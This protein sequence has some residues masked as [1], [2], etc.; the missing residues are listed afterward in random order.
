MAVSLSAIA[1]AYGASDSARGILATSDGKNAPIPA[2]VIRAVS[3]GGDAAREA[4]HLDGIDLVTGE[5]ADT[6]QNRARANAS[7]FGPPVRYAVLKTDNPPYADRTLTQRD[8]WDDGVIYTSVHYVSGKPVGVLEVTQD[9]SF[10]GFGGDPADAALIAK[11][12]PSELIIQAGLERELYV[13]TNDLKQVR[14]L[15]QNAVTVIGPKAIGAATFRSVH[16]EFE[17]QAAQAYQDYLARTYPDGAPEGLLGGPGFVV[18]RVNDP[19]YRTPG[20]HGV[21]IACV[22]LCIAGAA[23]SALTVQRRR[24]QSPN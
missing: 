21:A 10:H 2:A 24:A 4:L 22:G 7:T 23:V 13:A 3:P 11:V 14:P 16:A 15:N 9:G 6:A 12:D 17:A 5:Y 19:W 8:F 18:E 20:F 1:P